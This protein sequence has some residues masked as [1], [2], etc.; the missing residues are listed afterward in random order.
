MILLIFSHAGLVLSST[1]P[2]MGQKNFAPA[3]ELGEIPND[4]CGVST[5]KNED[6]R[7]E[8][9]AIGPDSAIY[10][11]Y[12]V[13]P[14]N[15]SDWSRWV[16]LGGN[17]VSGPAVTKDSAGRLQI[18]SRGSDRAYWVRQQRKTSTSEDMSDWMALGGNFLSA[19]VV[20]RDSEG[21]IHIFGRGED[22]TLYHR[23]QFA[24]ASAN[25]SDSTW[26]DWQSLG[27]ILTGHPSVL[28]DPEGLLHVFVRAQDRALWHLKQMPLSSEK[29]T[30]SWGTWESMG[31]VLASSPRVTAVTNAA[32]L[33]EITVRSA[34]KAYWV[35]TQTGTHQGGI[36]WSDWKNLGGIMSS[37]PALVLNDEGTVDVFGRGPDK[38]VWHKHQF[39]AK[40]GI[41]WTKWVDLGG[42]TAT[43]PSGILRSDS[44][45]Q[46]FTAGTDRGIWTRWQQDNNGSMEWGDWI[47]LGGNVKSYSC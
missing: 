31:G 5:F 17:F 13:S 16:S 6:D 20:S 22:N 3:I 25:K 12:Q 4:R 23:Q 43:S 36:Q 32:N 7:L 8:I 15:N 35:K 19:P 33:L 18:F 46:I 41:A 45:L 44:M 42:V 14:N 28:L 47:S 2:Q 26:T 24:L 1:G 40:E 21:F 39:V 29:S 37:G 30:V 34:D 11:K 10:H 38:H 27:G 9:F